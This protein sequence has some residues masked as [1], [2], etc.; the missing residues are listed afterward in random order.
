MSRQINIVLYN[1]FPECQDDCRWDRD[2]TQHR[3]A[4][5][6]RMESGMRPVWEGVDPVKL[7]AYCASADVTDLDLLLIG[8]A[9]TLDDI[10][11]QLSL[12]TQQTI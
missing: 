8:E 12:F 2:C 5:D 3:S 11:P 9:F 4:G 6:F 10:P 1:R 7:V